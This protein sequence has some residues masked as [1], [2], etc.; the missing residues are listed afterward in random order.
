M[1]I[2]EKR[3]LNL[4]YDGGTKL[5]QVDIIIELLTITIQNHY[6]YNGWPGLQAAKWSTS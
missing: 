6:V 5:A 3:A 1:I 4:G 2:R